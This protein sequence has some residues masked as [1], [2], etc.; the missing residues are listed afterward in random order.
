[1]SGTLVLLFADAPVTLADGS[2][3]QL[4]LPVTQPGGASDAR[5]RLHDRPF[6]VI[7]EEG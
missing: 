3:F 1:V 7:L 6:T 5:T 4:R 2:N